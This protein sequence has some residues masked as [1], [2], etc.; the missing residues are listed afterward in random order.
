M[1]AQFGAFLT[2]GSSPLSTMVL[3]ASGE[4]RNLVSALPASGSLA[5]V[6]MPAEN[7]VIFYRPAGSGPTMSM[8]F[9]GFS[10]LIC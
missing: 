2:I 3:R 5:L 7:T 10:S 8:P 6:A 4:L 1:I 9:T